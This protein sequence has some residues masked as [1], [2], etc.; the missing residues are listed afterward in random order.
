MLIC[1]YISQKTDAGS[2]FQ[3]LTVRT[4]LVEENQLW[5]KYYM[6]VALLIR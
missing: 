5:I 6:T 1:Y 4:I 3:N 2:E